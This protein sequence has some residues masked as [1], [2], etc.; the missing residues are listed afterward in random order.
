MFLTSRNFQ[1]MSSIF[2]SVFG[3][4]ASV[5]S[6]MAVSLSDYLLLVPQQEDRTLTWLGSELE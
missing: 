5:A 2:S 1:N 4:I 6:Q 3:F